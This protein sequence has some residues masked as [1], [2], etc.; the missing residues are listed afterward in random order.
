MPD[1][2]N[3]L[4][5]AHDLPPFSQIQPEHFLPA[6]EQLLAESRDQ[7]AEIIKTQTPFPTWDDLVLAMDEI[8]ARLK[9]FDYLLDCLTSTRTGEAWSQASLDCH[10]RLQDF[11]QSLARNAELFRLYRQLAD[12]QIAR[13]FEPA[14]KRVLE[15]I[16]QRFRRNGLNGLPSAVQADLNVLKR[17]MREAQQRFLEH[18]QAANKA[19][20]K[21]FDD[22]RQ[23]SGLPPAFKQQ[24]ASQARE[25]GR[26]GWLLALT[27][28]SFGIVT[29]YADNRDLREEI[30]IAYSTR[31]SDRGPHAQRFDNG[32]V[33]WQLLQDRRRYAHLLGYRDFAQMAIEPDQ[34]ESTDQVIAFL[35][36]Q[37]QQHHDAFVRDSEHLKAFA[38]RQ[39]F[40]ELRPWD[41]PYLTEKLRQ[42][43]TGFSKQALSAWFPLESTFSQLRLIAKELFGVDLIERQ[44]VASW[45]PDVRLFEVREWGGP[46]GYLY[47]DP[48]EDPNTGGYPNTTVLR[49][50]RI[51][52]EGRPCHPIAALHAW[53]PRSADAKPVLL[54]HLQ[55][56][57]LLHEFGH[58]LH[59]LLSRAEYRDVSGIMELSSDTSEFAGVLFEQWCF[60]R[61]CLVRLSRHYQTGKPLPDETADQLLAFVNTQASWETAALLRNAL[62]DMELHRS[63]GDG[64]TVQQVFDQVSAQVGHLPVAGDE[65]WPNALDYMVTGYAARI[66]AYVWSKEL[67]LQVFQRF[68]REGLFNAAT[69]QALRETIFGPG[70][71]RPL[72]ESIAAFS[73]TSEVTA[74]E[75]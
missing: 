56:R 19:W 26:T 72:A 70:D 4:L 25:A 16:L 13:H 51:T 28:E 52:A 62:F 41:Y 35:E 30:Y 57:V 20:S 75:A 5:Q 46:I 38:A 17:R 71:S 68:K 3:P 2:D 50:R 40:N 24:M 43:T 37:L 54:N 21:V 12:S 27:D 33:L 22:E 11:Q 69:G 49:N 15:K 29:S 1:H 65:R 48:F 7:V 47:F 18:L 74:R 10:Q 59:H 45:H 67:A 42:R 32:P 63:H 53:L 64:R 39:G 58:C 61:E 73:A 44:D 8:H 31:A 9:G 14:R 66:Y 60:S 6:L 36:G 23:L 55:L 34:A